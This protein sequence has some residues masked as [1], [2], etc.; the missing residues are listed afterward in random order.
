MNA[1]TAFIGP[2]RIDTHHH[3]F[4]DSVPELVSEFT[5]DGAQAF[6]FPKGVDDHLKYMDSMGIQTAVLAPSIKME[7]HTQ[8][9]PARWKNLCERTLKAQLKVQESN[10]LRFGTFAM[11]PFP[12]VNETLDFVRDIYTREVK[13]D[14]FALSTAMGNK[15]LGD[16]AFDPM[17]DELN[18]H[19]AAI[20]VHPADTAMPPGL[21]YK[22]YVFEYAFDTARAMAST[23]INGVFTRY[24][25]LKFIFSHNGGAFPFMAK[26]LDD[27]GPSAK[28]MNNGK[29]VFEVIRTS[30]IFVDTAISAPIQWPVTLDIG[31]PVERII[32]A[33]DY[34]YT[35]AVGEV[36][37]HGK[38]AP[39]ESGQFTRHEL[40]VKIAREN[41]LKGLFPRLAVEYKKAF[42]H[43]VDC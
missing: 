43:K 38:T 33:S 23:I 39:E 15:Y 6:F 25:N 14:G 10:P 34:P 32:Y 37:Y 7:W 16:P 4:G 31:F 2:G 11:L 17:W 8:W 28:K 40:D 20:F 18:M 30:N 42:G 22:P 21:E 19:S 5:N 26:R 29:S 24:P 27:V 9:P 1:S 35:A 13:P 41:A 12:H 3:Y 36:A